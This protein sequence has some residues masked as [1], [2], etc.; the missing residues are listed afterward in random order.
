MKTFVLR[1]NEDFTGISG[2]GDV[3]EGAV[4]NS[5]KVVVAW[6]PTMTLAKVVTVV[7]FDSIEDVEKL[8]GHDGAT[9][10]VWT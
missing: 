4:F 3:A 8:H 2:T 1:R 10:I 7:V 5:G 9:E 6:D